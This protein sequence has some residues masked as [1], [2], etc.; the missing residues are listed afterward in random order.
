MMDKIRVAF[1]DDEPHVLRGIS[2]SMAAME[3]EWEMVFC[4]SGEEALTLVKERPFD[5]V[6]SDMRMP[7]M[8]GAQL[9]DIIR[10]GY[11][12]TVRVILSGYADADSV[13]RT[14]GPAHIYLA[15]PCD[16]GALRAAIRR[17]ISLRSLLESPQMRSTLAGLANLPSLPKLYVQLQS[18]LLSPNCSAKTVA[19][20][21]SHDV[22]MT[23]EI[24]K[25]TNSAYFSAAGGGR[26]RCM[27]CG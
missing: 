6:V 8:D 18:E 21:I 10:R 7:G 15:K 5:V 12:S 3:D 2:R 23:A 27:R 16:A 22:A 25:L 13:L 14:V 26:R 4:A 19:E 24:L 11:P 17:Q 1:V 20:I 9:L